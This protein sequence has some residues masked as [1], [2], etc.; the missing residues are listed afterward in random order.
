VGLPNLRGAGLFMT[1]SQQAE[2][3]W[4]NLVDLGPRRL[5]ALGLVGAV[6]IAVVALGAL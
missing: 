2:R 6:V 5:A 3:L 1:G 4:T